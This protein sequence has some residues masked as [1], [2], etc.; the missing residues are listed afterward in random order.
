MEK[1]ILRKNALH[2][3]DSLS[4]DEVNEK[5]RVIVNQLMMTVEYKKSKFIMCYVDFRNEVSTR[6]LINESLK[7][8]KRVA[9]PVI[10]TLE[11]HK[12]DMIPSEISTIEELKPGTYGILEPEK[13]KP[14][15]P[16]ELDLIVVPGVAFDMSKNRIGYGAGYYDRFLEKT[17]LCSKIGLAFEIQINE[18]IFCEDHDI[19]L[20]R[21]I[22]EER[23]L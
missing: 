3:R 7:L 9:V 20:D 19:A 5:S 15:D 4:T 18:S 22:T 12:K 21:I 14:V 8:G 2:M 1:S 16:S 6:T 13:I 10:V 23:I 17:P 11:N